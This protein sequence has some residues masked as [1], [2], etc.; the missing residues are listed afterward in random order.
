[1]PATKQESCSSTRPAHF[2]VRESEA[3]PARKANQ[4]ISYGAAW[5]RQEIVFIG[6][7]MDEAAIVALLDQALLSDEEMVR[8]AAA[9]AQRQTQLGTLGCL[10][11]PVDAC[12][13][14][15]PWC[16]T[17]PMTAHEQPV[18]LTTSF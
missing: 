15:Y 17:W 18:Q 12:V 1:M 9:R 16:W 8:E 14:W 13:T 4:E 2:H 5:C 11:G 6:A 10:S 7:G 3:M